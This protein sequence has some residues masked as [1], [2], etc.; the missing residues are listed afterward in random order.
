MSAKQLPPVL[1]IFRFRRFLVVKMSFK[2]LIYRHNAVKCLI[3]LN[4]IS[5]SKVW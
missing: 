5:D 3:Q 2:P 4:D 1:G